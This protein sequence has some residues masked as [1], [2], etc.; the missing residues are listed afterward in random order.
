MFRISFGFMILCC[1]LSKVQA[2][3]LVPNGDFEQYNACPTGLTGPLSIGM[4]YS[5]TYTLFPSVQGWVM[6][7][8]YA[9][10]DYFNA[11]A[12][13]VLYG[14]N[15]VGVPN[16]FFSH[17]AARSGNGYIG[18]YTYYDA[19]PVNAAPVNYRE[20]ISCKLLQPLVPGKKY[21]VSFYVNP[22]T[23]NSVTYNPIG[24]D[25]IGASFTNL[26]PN[27]PTATTL[28]LPYQVRNPVGN[29]IIDTGA[30]TNISGTF[31]ATGGEEWMTIGCFHNSPVPGY[32]VIPPDV[33]TPA[34]GKLSYT[35]IEDVS[36]IPFIEHT[37]AH[38]TLICNPTGISWQV[39]SPIINTKYT[40][41]TGDTTRSIVLTA[42][43]KYWVVAEGNC[44]SFT[45]TFT[46]TYSPISAPQLRD[47]SICQ[48]TI[49][50]QIPVAGNV[51][52]YVNANDTIGS[53]NQPF[54]N[55]DS[56]GTITLYAG[57][58]NGNCRSAKVTL[59][60]TII[61]KPYLSLGPDIA[62]CQDAPDSASIGTDFSPATYVWNTGN[63]SCCITTD[64][65][66]RYVLT[67]SNI[68]GIAS[69]SVDI[70]KYR[71]TDC[72][73]L[74]NAFTPNNDGKNDVFRPQFLCPVK[75]YQL[76]IY[77]RWGQKLFFTI[78][79]EIGWDGTQ[80][81]Q[82]A[83]LGTFMYYMTYTHA[84]TGKEFKLKGDVTLIR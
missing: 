68:C 30:W 10:P 55:T 44:E 9:T 6:P 67:I 58:V 84:I 36:V 33:A 48:Y 45:D 69:D 74:P 23:R 32:A 78:T 75:N 7:L 19:T 3:N 20:F 29:Y 60:I 76:S 83:D 39:S 34:K 82:P 14:A 22:A 51:I 8:Q 40:W 49:N 59:T 11:C 46:V 47:T 57:A 1:F 5:P 17:Q 21:C 56:T 54:I 70:T 18:M 25:E 64:K 37:S 71:C 63:N 80:T 2:Q 41:N 38:D 4:A 81:T 28:T 13:S 66:G 16:N 77:N 62:L 35:Y 50:P 31:T 79:P 24:L 73:F 52:W 26:Q 65:A 53:P 15:N 61:A 27:D 72:V 12:P 42:P 43:G